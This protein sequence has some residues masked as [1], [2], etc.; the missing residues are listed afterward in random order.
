MKFALKQ[1]ILTAALSLSL[2]PLAF[3]DISFSQNQKEV[4]FPPSCEH[5]PISF[6]YKVDN[7]DFDE[8]QISVQ[9]DSDW[10]IASIDTEQNTVSVSFDNSDLI[11]SYTATISVSYGEETKELLVQATVPALDVYRLIDDPTRSQIYGIQ[12]NGIKNGSVFSF[13]PL[14]ESMEGCLTVGK[15]P[16]DFVIN[17]DSSELLV[18]N[19]ISQTI[20]VIDLTSFSLKESIRL[21]VYD[22]WSTTGETTANIE[23]GP[24]GIIYYVDGKWDP[25][26]RVLNRNSNTVIQ[27]LD[28]YGGTVTSNINGFM[29]LA[30]TN[31]KT[32]IV[33]MP[34]YGWS[35]GGHSSVI[36]QYKIN[37]DGIVSFDKTTQINNFERAP[38]EAPVLLTENDELAVLKTVAV[39]SGDIANLVKSFPSAIWSMTPNG[40]VV[41]TSDKLYAFDT[42]EELYQFSKSTY[43][44]GYVYS[45]AQTFTSDY[46]HFI[47]FNSTNRKL[48]VVDLISQI[49]ISALGIKQNPRDGAVVSV[50]ESLS[51]KPTAGIAFYDVYLGTSESGVKSADT[52]SSL[53]LG[54]VSGINIKLLQTLIRGTEYFW[55]IDPV[56]IDG[57]KTGAVNSFI[58]SNI[59]LSR[60][61]I[62]EETVSGFT[63]LQTS[64]QLSA[65]EAE[66][67]SVSSE[68]D[69]ISFTSNSGKTPSAIN[70]VLDAAKLPLGL[71]QSHITLKTDKGDLQI[72]VML[73]VNPLSITHIRSDRNSSTM[74]AISEDTTKLESSAYLL[75]IDSED[76]TIQK[77]LPVGS[78]VTDFTIHYLDNLIYVTNWKT[79]KLISVNIDSFEIDK[80]IEFSPAGATGYSSGDVYRIAA[81]ASQRVIVE[82]EDQWI[83]ISIFDTETEVKLD[84]EFVREGGGAFGPLG[85]YYYHGENNSS[86]ASIIK[87]DTS[88]DTFTELAKVRPEN[89]ASYYGSRTVVVSED[90]NRVFWA[91]AVFNNNLESEWRTGDIIYS[92][93]QNGRY[94]FAS[95]A[96]YDINLQRQVFGMPLETKI[97]G[98]NSTSEKLMV[99]ES[100]RLGFYN[101]SSQE[102]MPS[103]ELS[104]VKPTDTSVKLTWTDSS[105]EMG[106][107]I[108]WKTLGKTEWVDAHTTE[109]NETSWTINNLDA[110]TSYEFRVRAFTESQ[111]STWSN[112]VYKQEDDYLAALGFMLSPLDGSVVNSPES[113]SWTPIPWLTEYDVYLGV[114]EQDVSTADISSPVYMG[115]VNSASY[116]ILEAL[117][118]NTKY[119]WRVDPIGDEGP[120][121][122]A[123][124]SFTVSRIA[125]DKSEINEQTITGFADFKVGIELTAEENSVSWTASSEHSWVVLAEESGNTSGSLSITLDA[126][127]LPIGDNV[128][129]VTLTNVDGDLVIPITLNVEPLALQHIRSDRDSATVYAISEDTSSSTSSAYLI[130]IDSLTESIQRV[131]PVGS[132]V[133]DFAIH[134]ADNL[135]YV[136][137]WRDG[138]LL[139]IDRNSFD[140]TKT[141]AFQPAVRNGYGGGDVFSIAAGRSQRIIVEEE[142]QWIDINLFDSNSGAVLNSINS[143][144][145]GGAFSPDGRYYF[146]GEN[147]ISN[148]S[149]TKYDTSGD[150]FTSLTNIR[151]ENME[152]YYGAR[153]VIV[154]EEGNRVFWSGV[155]FDSELEQEWN[156]PA[157][158]Y[159]TSEDGRYA[160]S[161]DKI[162]DVNLRRQVLSMPTRTAVSGYNSASQ[163]LVVQVDGKIGFYEISPQAFVP[164]P[165]LNIVN[166]TD[167]SIVLN[168]TDESL[169]MGFVIQRRV[170]GTGT[171]EDIY[172]ASANE[173]QWTDSNIVAD[174]K[175]EYRIKATA[176]INDSLWSNSA[177][178]SDQPIAYDDMLYMTELK[179]YTLNVTVNDIDPDGSIDPGS[180]TIVKQPSAGHVSILENGQL[181]YSP[182]SDFKLT[183]SFTY[184]VSDMNGQVTNPATVDLVYIPPLAISF[185]EQSRNSVVLAWTHEA[186]LLWLNVFEVQK[187]EQG[188]VTWETLPHVASDKNNLTVVELDVAKVYEFRIRGMSQ[189]LST[190]WS[191]VLQSSLAPIAISDQVLMASIDEVTFNITDNDTDPEGHIDAESIDIVEDPQF[192][193][194]VI[195][196]EG[197]VTYIPGSAFEMADSFTYVVKDNDGVLSNQVSV[198]IRYI[199]APVI[200]ISSP[201]HNSVS[202][203]WS[204]EVQNGLTFTFEIQQR[205]TGGGVWQ[206]VANLTDGETSWTSAGLQSQTT[207]EFRLLAKNGDFKTV[208]SNTGAINTLSKP[209]V[210]PVQPSTNES[211][212]GTTNLYCLILILFLLISRRIRSI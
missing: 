201:T 160:F 20:D 60:N 197:N 14:T 122:G 43:S 164:A 148:A 154:S 167:T 61:N 132:S 38:F 105:L 79:G 179:Q 128:S 120:E 157:I 92:T 59:A 86:G 58:V 141:I 124:Y 189:D 96:I 121:S 104:L 99:E 101:L 155:V 203:N 118:N 3:A 143:R 212:G 11:A 85:R 42:G 95:A 207:Y 175:Y 130:E 83:D 183:D 150:V 32:R 185:S 90:G 188:A 106:F 33:A 162:Y 68:D 142:E 100:G 149:I 98:F 184:S 117:N 195:E 70:I 210:T 69:W 110:Q 55:R 75:E 6:L 18:I 211:S 1:K 34:Q 140:V 15:N 166:V 97:S 170:A 135:L 153:T 109:A 103:P 139:V 94:A 176:N 35:A 177:L 72:P 29:D 41:A 144:E 131:S 181:S 134:Y 192:G 174:T 159:S 119:Y 36:G 76:E 67:W 4:V 28:F 5:V 114:N 91:G 21:P 171:W 193:D 16:T 178:N 151:P 200:D 145:G 78:S 125:L 44:S 169:E 12:K 186:P 129:S 8:S 45:K 17:D 62:E 133:T 81:G 108:Q 30:V 127:E 88:D 53:Y 180:V 123:V 138:K 46:S 112:S 31:D 64:I 50:L 74:Y 172:I 165:R 13:N 126:R 107:A 56:G 10:A 23:L 49:G 198:E 199:N 57:P 137:N 209:V 205:I 22:D 191:N 115:R 66:D 27:S 54:Q 37:S 7:T 82:E 163:K 73:R 87:F 147:N 102:G 40:K 71:N 84:D 206:T 51:W 156:M 173:T 25:V 80:T 152:N 2:S 48:E 113:L 52:S 146:H 161:N 168:W 208:W 63:G 204:H 196:A 24:E 39:D 194:V 93:S 190:L 136:T 158:I 89:I 116:E 111:S 65:D 19:S 187:R 182:N 47:H 9:S 202:V 26:L 77:I